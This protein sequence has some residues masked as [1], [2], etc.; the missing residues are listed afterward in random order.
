MEEHLK[1]MPKYPPRSNPFAA[2]CLF[3]RTKIFCLPRQTIY[4]GNG[5]SVLTEIVAYYARPFIRQRSVHIHRNSDQVP[6]RLLWQ[7][8]I[9]THQNI[10][11]HPP[12]PSIVGKLYVSL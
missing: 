10:S 8:S 6:N 7:P 4:C 12:T 5:L 2:T 1:Y 9:R 11:T 3:V